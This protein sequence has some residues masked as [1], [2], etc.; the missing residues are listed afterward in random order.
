MKPI[1]LEKRKV[2]FEVLE[3]DRGFLEGCLTSAMLSDLRRPPPKGL[4][5]FKPGGGVGDA[6]LY[7]P[8]QGR[9]GGGVKE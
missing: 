1:E 7:L 2:F 4:L 9:G 3:R 5:I 6:H 8:T